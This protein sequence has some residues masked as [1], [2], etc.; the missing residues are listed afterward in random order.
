MLDNTGVVVARV[1]DNDILEGFLLV[2]D[3]D[4]RITMLS[5]SNIGIF[6]NPEYKLINA[7][8]DYEFDT[9][10][11]IHGTSLSKYPTIN[12]NMILTSKNGVTVGAVLVDADTG[13]EVGVQVF[14]GLG[15][16]FNLPFDKFYEIAKLYTRTNFK[17]TSDGMP[18]FP[19]NTPFPRLATKISKTGVSMTGSSMI[20]LTNNV[21]NARVAD[22]FGKSCSDKLTLALVNMKK[23]AP[24]YLTVLQAITRVPSTS[25]DTMAVSEDTLYY[26]LKFVAGLSVPKL[27]FVLIHEISHIMMQHSVRFGKR[28][29]HDLWNIACDLYINTSICQDFK[30]TYNSGEVK[31]N[32]GYIET[33]AEGVFIETTGEVIDLMKDTPESIYEKLLSENPNYNDN[34]SGQGG[35]DGSEGNNGNNGG[36]DSNGGSESNGT[37]K[38][39]G[40]ALSDAEDKA[41]S[42]KEVSVTFNGKKLTGTIMKDVSTNDNLGTED[43]ERKNLEKSKRALQRAKTAVDLAVS[44]GKLDNSK[45]CT[46]AGG[47]LMQRHIDYGLSAGL[48]WKLLLKTICK[49]IPKHTYPVSKPNPMYMNMGMT[50]ASRI[51]IGKDIRATNIKIAIDVSGSVTDTELS[52]MLSEVANIFKQAEIDGELIYWST[53]IGGVGAFSKAKDLAKVQPNSTGGT[54]VRCVFDYLSGKTLVNGKKE[55]SRV[56]DIPAV[57]ILTD[58]WFNMNF[59]DYERAFGRKVVWIITETNGNPITFNPPFGKVVGLDMSSI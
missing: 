5:M 10:G 41:G 31:F 33:L 47:K 50:V 36:S 1:I 12:K 37:G 2:S 4:N 25:I 52:Y 57:F 23:L 35:D 38:G 56:Q 24:Y 8:Y 22:E 14:N 55:E 59:K 42:M 17:I 16:S 26:N 7:E 18:V 58:G 39:L 27:T 30:V 46:Q 11:G 6:R 44:E 48:N 54:D 9:L 53:K 19:D 49:Q 51:E 21:V 45:D 20:R 28:K 40:D 15:A 32:D 34:G 3:T 13:K 29:S 43:S